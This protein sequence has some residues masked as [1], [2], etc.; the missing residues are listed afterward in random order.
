MNAHQRHQQLVSE[1]EAT[2][3]RLRQRS[4]NEGLI[5]AKRGQRLSRLEQEIGQLALLVR[6]LYV[7]QRAQPGFDP[8]RFA[9]IVGEIDRADGV[10]DGQA[11]MPVPVQPAVPAQP[12]RRRRT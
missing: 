9:A 4:I 11:R 2:L 5:N 6:A 10:A 3:E 1:A 8:A 12:L 7:Y